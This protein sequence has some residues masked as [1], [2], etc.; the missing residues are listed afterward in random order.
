VLINPA[1][2]HRYS[3]DDS[4]SG[5][6]TQANTYSDRT[7]SQGASSD[8]GEGSPERRLNGR[9]LYVRRAVDSEGEVLDIL[10]QPLGR[11]RVGRG[12]LCGSG[13]CP[14]RKS[15]PDVLV[16][17]PGQD[18]DG[19]NDTGPLDRPTQGRILA[20]RQVRARLIVI[21]RIR[22]KNSPQVRLR[23]DDGLRNCAIDAAFVPKTMRRK[24]AAKAKFF[25]KSQNSARAL[26]SPELQKSPGRQNCFQTR[27]VTAQ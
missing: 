11:T 17:Q 16:V 7:R 9:Q 25:Q 2:N 4:Q 26:P 21:R 8:P 3:G 1:R 10:V 18:W 27:A 6:G 20:Q 12:F 22:S 23:D 24:P 15:Y 19:D 13:R 5:C 14:F